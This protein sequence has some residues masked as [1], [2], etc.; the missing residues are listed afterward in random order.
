ML[1]TV[2]GSASRYHQPERA[3]LKL[4]VTLDGPEKTPVLDQVAISS[5]QIQALIEPLA[6]VIPSRTSAVTRWSADQ[7][8]VD[9][10]RPWNNEG[11]QLPLVFTAAVDFEIKFADFSALNTFYLKAAVISGV[12]I[13]GIT[14]E[15]TEP[16]LL[17]A[18]TL[19]QGLAVQ[20]AQT[21]ALTY[22]RALQK[23][24]GVRCVALA[25]PGMLGS[26]SGG[27]F[28]YADSALRSAVVGP[29]HAL[30]PQ[31]IEI[32]ARVDARFETTVTIRSV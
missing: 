31:E 4:R 9:A 28:G 32:T 25:D 29:E 27:S 18:T 11:R 6:R 21:K 3:T 12:V 5:N 7:I 23:D 10:Q 24:S 19:V 8:R 16:A 22:A 26:E 30:K 13:D 14:W 17:G 20:N 2:Q 15:L 1:I